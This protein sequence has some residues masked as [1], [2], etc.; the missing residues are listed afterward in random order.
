MTIEED[1]KNGGNMKN[2]K[3]IVSVLV[4][5]ILV[6]VFCL[7]YFTPAIERHTWVLA[8]AQRTDM[9]SMIV[10]HH[11][12]HDFS[13]VDGLHAEFSQP[14]ELICEAKSGELVLTD[15]TNGKTYEGTYKVS[16]WG[17]R[18]SGFQSYSIVING[19][20]GY[21]NITTESGRMLMI[22]IGGYVLNFEAE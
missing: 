5:V 7:F 22:S 18:R 20:E 14:I 2:R 17:G 1:I 4:S 21:A 9:P 15:Q 12:D 19:E 10:A 13:N 11:K 6:I 16:S 3:K 8:W